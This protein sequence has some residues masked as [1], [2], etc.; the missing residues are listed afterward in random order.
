MFQNIFRINQLVSLYYCIL[1]ILAARVPP[2]C[3]D[4]GPC[5]LVRHHAHSI[6]HPVTQSAVAEGCAEDEIVA[7]LSKERKRR[8]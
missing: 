2:I 6:V 4:N 1:K 8:P 3:S 5:E 7:G